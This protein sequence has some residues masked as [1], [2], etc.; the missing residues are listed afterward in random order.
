M[1][2]HYHKGV[3]IVVLQVF[4]AVPD[5]SRHELRDGLLLEIGGPIA[6][7]IEISVH[8]DKSLPGIQLVWR[9]VEVRRETAA[10]VPGDEQRL[11]SRVDMRKTTPLEFHDK[12]VAPLGRESPEMPRKAET[13]LGSAGWTACATPLLLNFY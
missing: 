7:R 12:L 1:I 10:E 13:N 4:G 6:G 2:R 8:P 9:R 11:A 3:Q 5:G